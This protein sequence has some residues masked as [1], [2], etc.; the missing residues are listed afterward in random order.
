MFPLPLTH[1]D[2]PSLACTHP[3]V[4]ASCSILKSFNIFL[5]H[6][7]LHISYVVATHSSSTDEIVKIVC[8]FEAL[9]TTPNPKWKT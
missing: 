6:I 7:S 9:D 5:I 8:F 3:F 4:V 1:H 2:R